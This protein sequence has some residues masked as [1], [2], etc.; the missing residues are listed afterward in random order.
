MTRRRL[1]A[2]PRAP[3]LLALLALLSGCGG[4]WPGAPRPSAEDDTP[5]HRAC[6]E[7][8]RTA[9]AVRALDREANPTSG[10]N[11]YRLAEERR[12]AEARAWR[13]CLRRAGL[14]QPGG[15]EA[16]RPR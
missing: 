13:D 16:I 9:P 8:A 10:A 3:A 12:L 2:P 7:E 1:P 14:A 4:L 5:A 15:V 11:A 6:R